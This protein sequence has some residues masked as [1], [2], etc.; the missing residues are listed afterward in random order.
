MIL[1]DGDLRFD[2]F[3]FATRSEI[4]PNEFR[5]EMVFIIEGRHK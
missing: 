2:K 3:R 4:M 5:W 1:L